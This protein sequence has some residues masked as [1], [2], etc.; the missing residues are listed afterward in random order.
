MNKTPEELA[1]D[2][3]DSGLYR[4]NRYVDG[5]IKPKQGELGW[6]NRACKNGFLAG[7]KAA[8]PQ[9]I[10]VK[11]RLPERKDGITQLWLCNTE[12]PDFVL[13]ALVTNYIDGKEITGVMDMNNPDDLWKLSEFT[14]WMKLNPL[15]EPPKEEE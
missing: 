8:A 6:Q 2:Y 4:L 7:Y 1:E 9:W 12:L 5:R 15:P 14:H 10:S 13:G 11:D 3:A